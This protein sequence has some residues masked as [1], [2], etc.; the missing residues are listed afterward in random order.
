M[1]CECEVRRYRLGDDLFRSLREGFPYCVGSTV[2]FYPGEISLRKSSLLSSECYCSA[3]IFLFRTIPIP[4][5]S[6]Y[7]SLRQRPYEET[8]GCLMKMLNVR[9]CGEGMGE[10]ILLDERGKGGF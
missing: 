4:F 8:G 9:M 1:S 6:F 2:V 5:V 7:P 3:C 10:G